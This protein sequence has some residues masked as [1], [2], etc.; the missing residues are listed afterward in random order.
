VTLEGVYDMV[1]NLHEWTAPTRATFRGGYYVGTQLKG[2]DATTLRTRTRG[3][4]WD[5]SIGFVAVQS[6]TREGAGLGLVA[7]Q[8]TGSAPRAA[9]PCLQIGAAPLG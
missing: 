8:V 5:Y 7:E 1:G 9:I 2:T 4:Y 3:T 6:I